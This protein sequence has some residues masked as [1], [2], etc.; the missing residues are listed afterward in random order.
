MDDNAMQHTGLEDFTVVKSPELTTALRPSTVGKFD[1]AL[2]LDGNLS[3]INRL[4]VDQ[5]AVTIQTYNT[6]T[7]SVVDKIEFK[8]FED[9]ESGELFGERIIEGT[10]NQVSEYLIR[11]SKL[12]TV[13]Y[14]TD[15]KVVVPDGVE[16]ID[17]DKAQGG[18]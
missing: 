8:Y 13:A 3:E 9:G 15:K 5:D 7:N 10:D 6:I 4:A 2:L 1:N 17:V 18:E 11:L 12:G 16:K 14:I